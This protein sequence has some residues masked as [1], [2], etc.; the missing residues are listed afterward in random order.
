LRSRQGRRTH[1][2][3]TRPCK[4]PAASLVINASGFVNSK[5]TGS[6]H[7]RKKSIHQ[8]TKKE[9]DL[10]RTGTVGDQGRKTDAA[11]E[12]ARGETPAV[13]DDAIDT[14]RIADVLERVTVA[15]RSDRRAAFLDRAALGVFFITRAGTNR[16]GPQWRR[17]ATDGFT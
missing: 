14:A 12:R 1:H 17:T 7:R 9:R 4:S 8:A 6:R 16:G 11:P 2:R 5:T 15:A 13:G 3:G 10:P